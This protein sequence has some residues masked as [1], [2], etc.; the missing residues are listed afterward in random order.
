LCFEFNLE[1]A[2]IDHKEEINEKINTLHYSN[3]VCKN[4]AEA[5][6]SDI[7]AWKRGAITLYSNNTFLTIFELTEVKI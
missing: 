6:K 7:E 5:S 4:N 2:I 1:Y 3:L